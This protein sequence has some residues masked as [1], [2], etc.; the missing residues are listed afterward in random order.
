LGNLAWLNGNIYELD[1]A[2]IGVQDRGFLFG[3]GVYDVIKI[4]NSKP[5]RLSTHL[6]RLEK[7]SL[8]IKID[9]P[10]S[11]KEIENITKELIEKSK[12]SDGLIYM[13]VTRGCT[14]RDHFFP[15]GVTPTLLIYILDIGFPPSKRDVKPTKCITLPDERWMNCH[16]KSTNLLPNVLAIQKAKE[17]S[18]GEAILFR[19]DGLITEGTRSNIFAVIDNEV[20]THPESNLIL[21]G[22]TRSIAIDFFRK[23]NTPCFEKAFNL[24]DLNKATEIWTTS[25]GSEI[26]P[27]YSVDETMIGEAVPG[28]VCRYLIEEFWKIVETECYS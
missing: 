11:K 28:P 5:F 26:T 20:R 16:I 2:K 15:T 9:I 10:N 3:D 8:A 18:G 17:A 4:Y 19:P 14:T 1:D 12:C 13:Q 27:V 24:E 25:T 22:I 21:A 6:D 23:S 7:S